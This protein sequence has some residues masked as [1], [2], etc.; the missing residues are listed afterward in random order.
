MNLF[1]KAK[2]ND[3]NITFYY[4]NEEKLYTIPKDLIDFY[5]DNIYLN[6]FCF[7]SENIVNGKQILFICLLNNL[8][9][10]KKKLK[11]IFKKTDIELIFNEFNN[12]CL[13][14]GTYCN[15]YIIIINSDYFKEYWDVRTSII[16]G[17]NQLF[18]LFND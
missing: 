9:V 1:K 13:C 3:S 17:F 16:N 6:G 8:K 12:R 5:E 15:G 11:Y 7:V 2:Y 10:W 18:H 14:I 4:V